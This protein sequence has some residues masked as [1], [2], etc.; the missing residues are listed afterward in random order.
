MSGQEYSEIIGA[1]AQQMDTSKIMLS[2]AAK[3]KQISFI[4]NQL[5]TLYNTTENAVNKFYE[6]ARP[7]E[8]EKLL[9]NMP[10]GDALDALE[11]IIS[12]GEGVLNKFKEKEVQYSPAM[13]S[14]F[15]DAIERVTS[16]ALKAE[17]GAGAYRAVDEFKRELDGINKMGQKSHSLSRCKYH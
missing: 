8:V 10:H 15:N 14:K 2:P 7:L 11:P 4:R 17:S 13:V 3:T 9:G 1:M 5:D 16:N 12:A 6:N